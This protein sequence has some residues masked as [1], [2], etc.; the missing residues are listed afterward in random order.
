MAKPFRNLNVHMT[1]YLKLLT[2]WRAVMSRIQTILSLGILGQV[3]VRIS[4]S[5]VHGPLSKKDSAYILAQQCSLHSILRMGN[6]LWCLLVKLIIIAL[7]RLCQQ[8]MRL[9][10]NRLKS[11]SSSNRFIHPHLSISTQCLCQLNHWQH[12]HSAG[13]HNPTLK[14]AYT[15]VITV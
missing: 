13:H 8:L 11:Y 9:A 2:L 15:Y 4:F 7:P 12:I 5:G 3:G 1:S 10:N 14:N 6:L